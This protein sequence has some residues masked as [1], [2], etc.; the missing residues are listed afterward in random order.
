MI[1]YTVTP[2]EYLRDSSQLVVELTPLDNT[3][4]VLLVHVNINPELL[5]QVLEAPSL[6]EQK[7][8]LRAEI[9]LG[10][11][12][13]QMQWEREIVARQEIPQALLDQL[14]VRGTTPVTQEEIDGN[15]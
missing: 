6:E 15:L 3:L 12:G 8:L 11:S 1:E 9:I 5:S 10:N 13:Y 7:A 2:V 4:N 14:G